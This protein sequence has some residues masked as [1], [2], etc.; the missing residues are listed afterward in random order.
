MYVC[1]AVTVTV[2]EACLRSVSTHRRRSSG[3][4]CTGSGHRL[5]SAGVVAAAA[6]CP[7]SSA[8]GANRAA[9]FRRTNFLANIFGLD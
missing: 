8:S 6:G 4:R 3:R 7:Q 5:P 9:G 1:V 2:N